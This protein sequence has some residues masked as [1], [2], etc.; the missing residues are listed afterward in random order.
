MQVKLSE[1]R[2]YAQRALAR[3]VLKK[4][5]S[6]LSDRR[7]AL[8]LENIT[9]VNGQAV[10]GSDPD[11]I[12]DFRLRPLYF[13]FWQTLKD[14]SDVRARIAADKRLSSPV[15][16]LA[17]G[18][19]PRAEKRVATGR[20]SEMQEVRLGYGWKSSV[21][22]AASARTGLQ[23]AFWYSVDHRPAIPLCM[24]AFAC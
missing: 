7:K 15:V 1:A 16:A 19:P 3:Y 5:A 18:G 8:R 6:N 23:G 2:S 24:P 17:L 14:G 22:C 4:P 12:M 13:D 9:L 20:D 11:L 21:L 10:F